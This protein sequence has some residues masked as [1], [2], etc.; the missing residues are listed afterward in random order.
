MTLLR[1]IASLFVLVFV[2]VPLDAAAL[3]VDD[4][5]IAAEAV[6]VA[7]DEYLAERFPEMAFRLRVRVVRVNRSAAQGE[8]LRIRP[9]IL[10]G[11][12]RGHTQ[13][14]LLVEREGGLREA[15]TALIFV[16]HF[17]SVTVALRDIPAG[18]EL[19]TSDV[20]FSWVEVTS[21]RGD[22][23]RSE[24]F[25]SRITAEGIVAKHGRKAGDALR[26]DDVRAPYAAESG[27]MVSMTYRRGP[28]VLKLNCKARESGVAG[29][30]IR[31]HS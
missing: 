14:K 20:A 15:G 8:T 27:E 9:A 28:V 12:P 2:L 22:A 18:Q 3:T 19:S 11:I 26:V 17:D 23:L 4:D 21:F 31:L 30:I 10:D 29:D 13:V 16:A 5:P 1:I 25:R 24:E 6:K 7:A